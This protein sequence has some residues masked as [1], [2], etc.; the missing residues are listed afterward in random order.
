MNTA[1][2]D[3][4]KIDTVILAGGLGTR[5]QPVLKDKPKCLAPINGTSFI[6]ILLDNCINQ[7]LRRFI[8]CVGYLKEQVI[9]HL[10]DRND[11]EI[12]FSK[13]D[14]LLGTGGALRNAEPLINS[15]PI[16]VMNGD[17]FINY[18]INNIILF[19]SNTIGTILVTKSINISGY[20]SVKV[21][22]DGF[23]TSFQEK[24]GNV[25]QGLVNTG[26]YCFDRK[27]F[28]FLR[29]EKSCSIECDLLPHLV[30]RN[31]LM[32][33]KSNAELI[34]IG[35]P[36]SLVLAREYFLGYQLGS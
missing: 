11:C 33:H 16:L 14:E 8:L 17:S 18:D 32:A 4:S 28:T 15:N 2:I 12:I 6:D 13:E 5:L 3:L 24:Y 1:N 9:E 31:R 10:S 21:N 23:V 34:D 19:E 36:E 7:G 22:E 27:V 35:T 25:P 30:Y 26:R 29:K 20:G